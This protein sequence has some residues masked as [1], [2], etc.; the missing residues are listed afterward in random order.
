MS[1]NKMLHVVYRVGNMDKTIKFYQD[2][3]GMKLLRYRDIPEEKYSNAFLG[4]GTESKGEHFSLELT[5]NYGKESYDIGDEVYSMGLQL[6]NLRDVAKKAK[7]TGAEIV[8][9]PA[10]VEVGPSLIPDEPVGKKT[11]DT[12][13]KLKDPDGWVFEI[14][15]ARNRRDPVSKMTVR[16]VDMEKSIDFYE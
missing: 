9:G 4:Y 2:V 13:L 8:F 12:I 7:A 15:E 11:V 14:K 6:P 10:D 5:Y 1:D 16:T 3:F